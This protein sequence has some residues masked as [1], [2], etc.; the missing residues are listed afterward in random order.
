MLLILNFN[1]LAQPTEARAES[2]WGLFA[3]VNFRTKFISEIN[4]FQ[5]RPEFTEA[6]RKNEG[7]E[8]ILKGYYMAF[9]LAEDQ[10]ILSQYS[11]VGCFF[12][13]SAGPESVAYIYLNNK[14]PKL[15]PDQV[16]AI[17]GKLK[18]NDRDVNQLTFILEDAE[19]LD[20]TFK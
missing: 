17:K 20:D 15:K 18:L 1:G 11:Y 8:I 5:L 9:N 2:G 10:L 19:L 16:I 12:C 4:E 7:R 3:R 6:F 13:G 14:R